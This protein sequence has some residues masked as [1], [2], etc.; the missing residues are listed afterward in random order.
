MSEF[1][2]SGQ[3]NAGIGPK[4]FTPYIPPTKS[5]QPF[6]PTSITLLSPPNL[7]KNDSKGD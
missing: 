6:T 5:Y 3:T 2:S 4:T 1:T 7:I